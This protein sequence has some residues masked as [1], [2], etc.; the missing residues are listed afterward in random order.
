MGHQCSGP[1]VSYPLQ[2]DGVDLCS[3]G[4]DGEADDNFGISVS[5]SGDYVIVGARQDDDNRTQAG[6]AYIFKHDGTSPDPPEF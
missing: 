5:I 1:S 2:D 3:I 6:V 4:T